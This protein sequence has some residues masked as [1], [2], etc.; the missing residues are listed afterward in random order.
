MQLINNW[1]ID[2]LAEHLQAVAEEQIRF[3]MINIGSGYAKV[4]Q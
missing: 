2:A 3:L 1:H 4:P